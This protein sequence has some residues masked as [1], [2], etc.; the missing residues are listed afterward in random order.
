M[1]LGESISQAEALVI[2]LTWVPLRDVYPLG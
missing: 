2:M 1:D